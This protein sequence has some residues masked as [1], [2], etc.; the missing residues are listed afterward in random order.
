MDAVGSQSISDLRAPRSSPLTPA[1][2]IVKIGIAAVA[3]PAGAGLVGLTLLKIFPDSHFLEAMAWGTFMAIIAL[4][5]VL[6]GCLILAAL[7]RK[8]SRS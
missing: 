5:T 4:V 3:V 1:S 2:L 8:F 7:V 6:P